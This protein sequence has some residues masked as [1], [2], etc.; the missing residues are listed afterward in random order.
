MLCCTSIVNLPDRCVL[1][2]QILCERL[3]KVYQETEAEIMREPS[4][5]EEQNQA[6]AVLLG[7]KKP[8]AL[9]A[10]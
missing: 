9:V 7:L 4:S 8:G 10:D 1:L 2:V 3:S 5:K 6:P